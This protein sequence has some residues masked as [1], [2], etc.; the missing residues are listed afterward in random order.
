MDSSIEVMYL[1][2]GNIWISMIGSELKSLEG[3]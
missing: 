2:R 3:D 1:A